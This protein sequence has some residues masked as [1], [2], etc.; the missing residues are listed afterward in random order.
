MQNV[1]LTI[2]FKNNNYCN[3]MSQPKYSK[4]TSFSRDK[5]YAYCESDVSKNDKKI[6]D[7]KNVRG[8][9]R[10]RNL[11]IANGANEENEVSENT[12]TS[13]SVNTS[14]NTSAT[15]QEQFYFE[16]MNLII[17]LIF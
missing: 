14:A 6:D 16:K 12:N 15:A 5:K 1:A 9:E 2:R 10:E 3:K 7:Y 17:L 13:A 4:K 11:K 8:L